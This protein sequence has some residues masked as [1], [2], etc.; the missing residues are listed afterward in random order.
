MRTIF[1]TQIKSQIGRLP[2]HIAT[3]N[4]L[5]LRHIGDSVKRKDTAAI[6]GM[7][8]KVSY[9]ISIQV[10]DKPCI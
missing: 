7:I 6:R 2:K 1:I 3:M 9:M 10:R 8:R 4:G 5:G